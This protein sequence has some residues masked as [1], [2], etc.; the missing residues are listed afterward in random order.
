MFTN[1]LNCLMFSVGTAYNYS[2]TPAMLLMSSEDTVIRWWQSIWWFQWRRQTETMTKTVKDL[3]T[4]GALKRLRL[5]TNVTE[6]DNKNSYQRIRQA[7]SSHCN[8][9]L[10]LFE[11]RGTA[12]LST[13]DLWIGRRRDWLLAFYDHNDNDDKNVNENYEDK[14]YEKHQRIC[15]P[16]SEDTDFW[17]S[18]RDDLASIAR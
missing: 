5:L 18:W 11:N 6:N 7:C 2:T 10:W 15:T 3:H 14:K 8:L 16:G 17:Q 1:I 9:G 12:M 13:K 4:L